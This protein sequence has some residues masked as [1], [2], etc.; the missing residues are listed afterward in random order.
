MKKALFFFLLLGAAA[1]VGL[2]APSRA[3]MVQPSGTPSPCVSPLVAATQYWGWVC[4]Y[5]S[6]Q[7]TSHY[8]GEARPAPSPNPPGAAPC[9]IRY[10]PGDALIQAPQTITCDPA[11]SVNERDTN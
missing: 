9:W 4:I 11:N 8:N 3:G 7:D 2:H 1:A 6:S 5:P 10:P